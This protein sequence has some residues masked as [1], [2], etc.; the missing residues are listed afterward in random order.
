MNVLRST[1]PN[2]PSGP[3]ALSRSTGRSGS[4]DQR[5]NRTTAP[6]RSTESGFTLLEVIVA[7]AIM[8]IAV[9]GLLALVSSSLANAARVK[10]SDRAAMLARRQM[11]ELM[12]SDPLPL[13]AELS[14]KF[15]DS[16]GWQARAEPFDAPAS[17]Q[18]GQPM[19]VRIQLSIWWESEGRRK[20][21]EFESYRRIMT[22]PE[23]L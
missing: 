11:G 17:K 5:I 22:R 8:A 3:I 7:T 13:G 4:T 19:L 16:T 9:I 10:E 20:S 21:V 1:A 18:A 2:D 6:N 15:D 23:Q 14:G 12:V